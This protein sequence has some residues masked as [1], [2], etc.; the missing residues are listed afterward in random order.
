MRFV[1]VNEPAGSVA[2]KNN[3]TNKK[4]LLHW[5]QQAVTVAT[6]PDTD[7]PIRVKLKGTAPAQY[8]LVIR[9]VEPPSLK[10]LCAATDFTHSR[11]NTW[12]F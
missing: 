10:V 4:I 11:D 1:C 12:H 8:M 7:T 3:K 5:G 2:E 6:R 9:E